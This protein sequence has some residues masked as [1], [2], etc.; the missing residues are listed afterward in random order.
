MARDKAKPKR[1]MTAYNAFIQEMRKQLKSKSP[2]REINF[3]EFSKH[4]STKWRNLTGN[5]KKRYENIAAKDK[6]RF[7]KE[8]KKYKPS[9]AA[10]ENSKR[11]V[12]K[13]P[14]KPK[15]ALS[16]FFMFCNQER[17]KIRAANPQWSVGQVAKELGSR[18]GNCSNKTK[19]QKLAEQDKK[20][21]QKE[22]KTYT[23]PTFADFD[24]GRRVRKDPNKPK[25]ALSSFFMFC[26]EERKKVTA[27]NPYLSIGEVAKELGSRWEQCEDRTK[28]QR[29]ADRDR[30]RYA[31]EMVNYN[32]MKMF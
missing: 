25:R 5:D 28:Y 22:M 13:D 32:S 2:N 8:M 4:C 15:K 20:R 24:E 16:S 10:I 26:G 21:Y 17:E 12:G 1:A 27:T 7:K 6:T 23:P 30:K 18:W 29:M 19:F 9:V 31:K 11:K 14:N 3:I